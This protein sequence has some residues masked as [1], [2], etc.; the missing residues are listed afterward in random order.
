MD[1]LTRNVTTLSELAELSGEVVK[2]SRDGGKTWEYG[3]VLGNCAPLRFTNAEGA[4]YYIDLEVSPQGVP[5]RGVL[6]DVMLAE[7]RTVVQPSPEEI[8]TKQFSY[9]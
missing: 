2:I 4:G 5:R 1:K 8:K 3:I 6:T 7:E 9:R